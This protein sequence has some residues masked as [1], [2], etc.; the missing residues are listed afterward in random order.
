MFVMLVFGDTEEVR[1][2]EFNMNSK[3]DKIF[4]FVCWKVYVFSGGVWEVVFR[5]I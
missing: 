4:I 1:I 2:F 5:I 3:F